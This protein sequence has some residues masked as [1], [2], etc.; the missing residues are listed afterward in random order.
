[1][2]KFR[3]KNDEFD[4]K[5]PIKSQPKLTLFYENSVGE[6]LKFSRLFE[7]LRSFGSNSISKIVELKKNDKVLLNFTKKKSVFLTDSDDL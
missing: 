2:S 6:F 4:S 1:M 3:R 7:S 5:F